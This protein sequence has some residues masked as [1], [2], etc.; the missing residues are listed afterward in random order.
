MNKSPIVLTVFCIV[1]CFVHQASAGLFFGQVKT[2]D[3]VTIAKHEVER[4]KVPLPKKYKVSV[5]DGNAFFEF[6]QPRKI[7]VVSFAFADRAKRH[8]VYTVHVDKRSGKVDAFSD[9]RT[10]RRLHF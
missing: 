7:Y 5:T 4:R 2:R 9:S 3:A 8:V 10:L 1:G 6:E